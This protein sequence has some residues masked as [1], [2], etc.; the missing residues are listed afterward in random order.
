MGKEFDVVVVGGRCAGS[1]LAALLADDAAPIKWL[2]ATAYAVPKETTNQGSGYF[3][4]VTG[5]NGRQYIGTAKY[6]VNA[7]LVEFDKS[8]SITTFKY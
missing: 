8:R 6:G 3:S 7:F 5:R 4:I 1:P 2:P